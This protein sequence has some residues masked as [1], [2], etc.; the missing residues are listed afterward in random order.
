MYTRQVRVKN[1]GK[2]VK[3]GNECTKD[4]NI[5]E[6][7]KTFTSGYSDGVFGCQTKQ[8]PGNQACCAGQI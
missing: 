1:S 4:I 5:A 2:E 6:V 3:E 7:R 8:V